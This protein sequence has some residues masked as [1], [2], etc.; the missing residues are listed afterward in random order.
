MER[1][2]RAVRKSSPG[3]VSY[4][5]LTTFDKILA[6]P[7]TD[8]ARRDIQSIASLISQQRRQLLNGSLRFDLRTETDA[9]AF[10]AWCSIHLTPSAFSRDRPA[11]GRFRQETTWRSSDGSAEQ[12]GAEIEQLKEVLDQDVEVI[13][14]LN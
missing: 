11:G 7:I 5:L 9:S 2:I 13:F 3:R 1:Q 4:F 12:I 10:F 14:E 8:Q 6:V